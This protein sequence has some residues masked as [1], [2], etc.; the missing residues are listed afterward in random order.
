V[1]GHD[2]SY[3]LIVKND[4]RIT[5]DEAEL[6]VTLPE[7]LEVSISGR[8]ETQDI[9]DRHTAASTG[10]NEKTCTI[11]IGLMHPGDS[12]AI[13]IAART[14]NYSED[15]P[16]EAN[17][18]LVLRKDPAT[19]IAPADNAISVTTDV[20]WMSYTPNVSEN[21]GTDLIVVSVELDS[22]GLAVDIKNDGSSPTTSP[23]WVDLYFDPD[24]I[25]TQPNDIWADG[26]SKY[27]LVWHIDPYMQPGEAITLTIGDAYFRPLLSR[28][29]G[30]LLAGMPIYVQVDSA[31]VETTYGGVH[32]MHEVPGSTAPYN[33]II[34]FDL[35]ENVTLAPVNLTADQSEW[36]DDELLPSRPTRN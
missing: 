36:N 6:L 14:S 15:V 25:P 2:L 17:F 29:P 11:P 8:Q 4:G 24:P 3:E 13:E 32:E 7:S 28:I 23:F 31:N 21:A 22:E 18:E 27:G 20:T 19:D 16:I 10:D 5:V 35:E 34:S 30:S 1:I 12:R 26:R 9:C 33:N